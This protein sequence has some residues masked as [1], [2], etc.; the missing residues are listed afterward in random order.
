MR[1]R[2]FA[3]ALRTTPLRAEPTAAPKSMSYQKPAQINFT[4][5]PS[6][7]YA[8]TSSI[9]AHHSTVP[10]Y[11]RFRCTSSAPASAAPRQR[12]SL[13]L[14]A[15][16]LGQ[17]SVDSVTDEVTKV[18]THTVREDAGIARFDYRFND[19]NTAYF[20]YNV[21]HAYI[22]D[23]SD[24]LGIISIFTH[25]PSDR[26]PTEAEK[27]SIGKLI[28]EGMKAGWL[29]AT[30]GV[31]FRRD[32]RSRAQERRRQGHGHRRSFCRDERGHRRLRAAQSRD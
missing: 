6:T 14:D 26:P 27:A 3:S 9:L 7:R 4:A 10:H 1:S 12:Q 15:Y 21:D 29:I 11:H 31:H 13:F 32:W 24:A 16:P 17:K 25:E 28:E 5:E 20:R 18:A 30:E 19:K 2:S 23:P 22:D 8:R